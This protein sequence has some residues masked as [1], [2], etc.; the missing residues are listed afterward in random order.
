MEN[1][2]GLTDFLGEIF[3]GPADF[4]GDIF[5]VENESLMQCESNIKMLGY[6]RGF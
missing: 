3:R 1:S 4:L 2:S 6:N 5:E